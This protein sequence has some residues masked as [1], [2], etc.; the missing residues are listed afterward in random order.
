MSTKKF[1]YAVNKLG[2]VDIEETLL[3]QRHIFINS[4]IDAFHA[5]SIVKELLVLDMIS[6]E[7]IQI[8]ITSPGGR[9]DWG[10][11]IINVMK[12]IRSKVITIANGQ[13]ASMGTLI[14]IAGDER[15]CFPN[16]TFMFHD[17]FSGVVDYSQKMK[18]RLDYTEK[19]YKKLE[20]HILDN[21]K[22]TKAEVD[23]SRS[24]ELWIFSDEAV[25]KGLVD[26]VIK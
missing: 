5:D 26:V 11:A 17:M 21:T 16:T 20:K 4:A 14:S 8:Y 22:L 6:G 7:P 25:K 1:R 12:R 2:N 15:K 13:V 10:F 18:A 24:E 9:V 23:V 3:L 19:L